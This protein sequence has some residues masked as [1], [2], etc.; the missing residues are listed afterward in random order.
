[1]VVLDPDAGEETSAADA[2][3]LQVAVLGDAENGASVLE[4][5]QVFRGRCGVCVEGDLDAMLANYLDAAITG[6][7][8][9]G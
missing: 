5:G 4:E 6:S 7:Y 2:V 3:E 9:Q 8:L 1:M